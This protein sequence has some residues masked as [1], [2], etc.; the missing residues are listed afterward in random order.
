MASL[1][2]PDWEGSHII[3]WGQTGYLRQ[4]AESTTTACSENG[5]YL[6]KQFTESNSTLASAPECE[7]VLSKYFRLKSLNY[8][9]RKNQSLI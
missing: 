9:I 5:I 1:V 2:A 3:A 8:L 7:E 4:A 6:S